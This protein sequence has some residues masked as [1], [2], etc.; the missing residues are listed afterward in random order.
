MLESRVFLVEKNCS[1]KTGSSFG[2]LLA[3]KVSEGQ[4]RVRQAV[5]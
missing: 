3:R 5:G 2:S 4:V 1:C